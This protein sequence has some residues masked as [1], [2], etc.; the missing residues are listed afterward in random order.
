MVDRIRFFTSV[1]TIDVVT[2][3]VMS[4]HYHLVV[5]SMKDK[6]SHGENRR[7]ADAGNS[8]TTI[9]HWLNVYNKGRAATKPKKIKPITSLMN[10]EV[11]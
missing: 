3:A 4:N 2:Y 5:I 11:A 9:T 1:F 7:C 8:F 10:G 6:H